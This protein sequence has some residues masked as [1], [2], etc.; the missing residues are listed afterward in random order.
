[1]VNTLRQLHHAYILLCISTQGADVKD[2]G[3][4]GLAAFDALSGSASEP[5]DPELEV[6]SP[7]L[8]A[9]SA[10]LDDN[11]DEDEDIFEIEFMMH[12]RNYYMDKMGFKVVDR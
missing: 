2:S 4:A 11:D 8:H 7:E 5:F 3:L 6:L 12:K 10:Q 1:M 9:L